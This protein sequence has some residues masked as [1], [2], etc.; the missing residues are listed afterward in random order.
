MC[1]ETLF[2]TIKPENNPNAQTNK[3]KRKLRLLNPIGYYPAIQGNRPDTYN[4]V[5]KSQGHHIEQKKLTQKNAYCRIDSIAM[6]FVWLPWD[7]LE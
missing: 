5:D 2:I 4:N 1:I 7:L 6:K 3:W